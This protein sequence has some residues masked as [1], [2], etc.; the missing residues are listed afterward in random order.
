[1]AAETVDTCAWWPADEWDGSFFETTCRHAFEFTAD[2]IQ[3]NDFVF[4]PFCGKRI[5]EPRRG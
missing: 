5:E 2:G 3:E 4:C 1:M